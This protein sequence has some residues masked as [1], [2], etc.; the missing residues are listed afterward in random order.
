MEKWTNPQPT[1]QRSPDFHEV[2]KVHMAA[3]LVVQIATCSLSR[4]L[5]AMAAK[6]NTE[7]ALKMLESSFDHES[8][9]IGNN[10]KSM[11]L[12]SASEVA[13]DDGAWF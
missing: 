13:D 12:E 9:D 6:Y 1:Y 7:T 8:D 10:A 2:I 5:V 11:A 3:V 4:V